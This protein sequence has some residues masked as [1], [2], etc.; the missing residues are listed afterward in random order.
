MRQWCTMEFVSHFI[1][2]VRRYNLDYVVKLLADKMY[3]SRNLGMKNPFL[4]IDKND[5]TYEELFCLFN[6][7]YYIS[8]EISY[9]SRIK[10]WNLLLDRIEAITDEVIYE[11]ENDIFKGIKIPDTIKIE[12]T[13][14]ILIL[15]F[16]NDKIKHRNFL[17]N[18]NIFEGN[19]VLLFNEKV[20]KIIRYNIY[21]IN[22]MREEAM[23]LEKTEMIVNVNQQNNV[24]SKM[25]DEIKNGY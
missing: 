1:R 7:E 12:E 10:L 5:D 25:K 6:K 19:K 13:E 17:Y 22:S 15:N 21:K 11:T 16:D 8:K 23:I 24:I 14:N 9:N 20:D 3:C 2:L 4:N 18:Q